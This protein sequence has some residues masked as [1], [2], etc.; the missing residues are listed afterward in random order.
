M[1]RVFKKESYLG[2]DRSNPMNH[3]STEYAVVGD[4]QV[5]NDFGRSGHPYGEMTILHDTAQFKHHFVDPEK[6]DKKAIERATGLSESFLM[7]KV[8]DTMQSAPTVSRAVAKAVIAGD[9]YNRADTDY[10]LQKLQHHLTDGKNAEDYAE[11][12]KAKRHHG[13]NLARSVSR[14][15]QQAP[16]V[17]H[18]DT[19]FESTPARSEVSYAEFDPSLRHM[20]PIVAAHASM[21]Y[22]ELTASDDLS[23]YSSK[24][25]KKAQQKGLPVASH[26]DNPESNR[27]NSMLLEAHTITSTRAEDIRQRA[28]DDFDENV[29]EIHPLELKDAKQHL[30]KMLRPGEKPKK[31][32]HQF[33]HLQLPGID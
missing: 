17:Y 7:H 31:I 18:P 10:R 13:I 15:R 11:A 9:D 21:E 24:L 5:T 30:R 14:M 12:V 3:Y 20:M 33:E 19:L 1:A 29:R 4:K 2:G 26:P 8:T 27:T 28:E 25:T 16:D 32:S 22:G 6:V 23:E